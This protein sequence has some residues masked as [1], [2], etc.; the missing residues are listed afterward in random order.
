MY[1]TTQAW[2][3]MPCVPHRVFLMVE[4]PTDILC[5]SYCVSFLLSDSDVVA[6]YTF[7]G[8][9][10]WFCTTTTLWSISTAGISPS[11]CWSLAH[12]MNAQSSC[13][14]LLLDW[15]VSH[16]TY[17]DATIESL[18]WGPWLLGYGIKYPDHTHS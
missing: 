2:S 6:F 16:A 11:W 17:L 12:A 15:G 3:F 8:S 18:W 1:V 10:V 7:G 13:S 9:A 4:P 14:P 5:W